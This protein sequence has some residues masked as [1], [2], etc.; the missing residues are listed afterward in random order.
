MEAGRGRPLGRD[1]YAASRAATADAN[2]SITG[3]IKPC[4][5][6]KDAWFTSGR[7][8][9]SLMYSTAISQLALRGPPVQR[10]SKMMSD[11]PTTGANSIE[12]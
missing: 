10:R 5:S 2:A 12:P 6:C 3:W 1:G 7:E 11:N 4:L 8:L 9:M